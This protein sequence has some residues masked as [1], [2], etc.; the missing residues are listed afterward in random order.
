MVGAEARAQAERVDALRAE[1]PQARASRAHPEGAVAVLEHDRDLG[2]GQASKLCRPC[3]QPSLHETV[4]TLPGRGPDASSPVTIER[5]RTAFEHE[6]SRRAVRSELAHAVVGGQPDGAALQQHEHPVAAVSRGE[7]IDPARPHE[8]ESGKLPRESD[9]PVLRLGEVRY[10]AAS[11]FVHELPAT[12]PAAGDAVW[13][14]GPERP[15]ARREQRP[16]LLRDQGESALELGDPLEA[17]AVEAQQPAR[18]RTKP[19]VTVRG[20]S[21]RRDRPRGHAIAGRPRV[22]HVLGDAAPGIEGARRASPYRG[23]QQHADCGIAD[24]PKR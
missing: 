21:D 2:I 15:I 6:P 22:V 17:D 23:E 4:E 9:R 18:A 14:S 5:V 11:A 8:A 12:A 19:E 16:N 20:L 10:F 24:G 7:E 3:V 1:T 13:R